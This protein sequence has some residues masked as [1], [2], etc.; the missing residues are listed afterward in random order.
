MDGDNHYQLNLS[1]QEMSKFYKKKLSMK[2]TILIVFSIHVIWMSDC[3]QHHQ[4]F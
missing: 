2:I 3:S 4:D 1:A